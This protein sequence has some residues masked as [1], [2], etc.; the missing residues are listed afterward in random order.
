MDPRH[1]CGEQRNRRKEPSTRRINTQCS[2]VLRLI[3]ESLPDGRHWQLSRLCLAEQ[4]SQETFRFGVDFD[5][6]L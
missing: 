6:K 1:A 4:V 2:N 5:G 3:A